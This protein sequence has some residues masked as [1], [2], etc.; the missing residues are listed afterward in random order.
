[1]LKN[2]ITFTK[3]TLLKYVKGFDTIRALAVFYVIFGHWWTAPTDHSFAY[4]SRMIFIREGGFGVNLF[5]VLS[6]FLISAILLN[7]K[8]NNTGTKLTIIKNFFVRRSLRIFPV[9]YLFIIICYLLNYAIV[10]DKPGYFFTYTS[11]LLP[12]STNQVNELSH[13]WTLSV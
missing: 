7:E 6:G 12:Y 10:R 13:T 4:Y 8:V 1:M 9:Y 11:N 2:K 3:R 5:F